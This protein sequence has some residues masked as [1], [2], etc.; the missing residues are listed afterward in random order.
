MPLSLAAA[1]L[2]A[3]AL[4]TLG[5]IFGNKEQVASAREQMAFQERMSNT[6]YQRAMKD[7][8]TAGLNPMLAYQRGGASTPSGAQANIKNVMEHAPKTAANYVAA[9]QATAQIGNIES[10]TDLNEANT[11]LQLEKKN[12]EI[13]NQGEILARTNLTGERTSTQKFLTEQE[14]VRVQTAFAQLGKTRMEAIQAEQMADRAINQGNIDRGELGQ[15]LAW[16]ER[17]KAVGLGADTV[18]QLLGKKKPGG[19][20]PKIGSPAN[21]FNVIN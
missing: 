14:R 21:N 15:L 3:G 19:P 5:G 11:A 4:S 20:F 10:Q 9:K 18:L 2:G 13:L 17:A 8:R 6:S 7:M 12:T 1:T 16:L